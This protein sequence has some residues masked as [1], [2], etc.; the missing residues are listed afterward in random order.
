MDF[1]NIKWTELKGKAT[2]LQPRWHVEQ[3]MT[4]I[5]IQLKI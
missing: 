4:F 2:K 1:K 5:E 3:R